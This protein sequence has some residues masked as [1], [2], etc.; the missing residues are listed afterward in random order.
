MGSPESEPGHNNGER[1]HSV[2]LTHRF[3][4]L[5]T[6]VTQ[7]QF[8][9]RMGYNPSVFPP[10]GGMRPVDT[11]RWSEAAAYCNA[12]SSAAGLAS[13]YVCSGS[14]ADVTCDVNSAYATP[15]ACPGYRLPTEAE[16]EFAARAGTTGGT[17]NGTCDEAHLECDQ[18]NPVLDSIAWFCGNCP[19]NTT[20]AVGTLAANPWGLFDMLGNVWELCGDWC[21]E[22]AMEYPEGP[23][24][25][26][27][28]PASGEYRRL[29]GG[30]VGNSAMDARAATRTYVWSSVGAGFRPARSLP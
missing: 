15:Y 18:P 11:A 6:E 29:R 28:G 26:P 16:W 4:I 21:E 20:H 1:Q 9:E 27:W 24:T 17:Y 19:D 2:T 10:F 3:E 5:S 7:A 8:L 22:G 30:G 13:C 25:D 23:A 14:G 12:L